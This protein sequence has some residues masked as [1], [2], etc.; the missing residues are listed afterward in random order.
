[1]TT[2]ED[3][4]LTVEV[5]EAKAAL[6]AA[7]AAAVKAEREVISDNH[8]HEDWLSEH[9]GEIPDAKQATAGLGALAEI[10]EGQLELETYELEAEAAFV[11]SA[12]VEAKLEDKVLQMLEM[13]KRVSIRPANAT[14]KA[15]V[16][17][18]SKGEKANK[19]S[20]IVNSKAGEQQQNK[21][22]TEHQ[23]EGAEHQKTVLDEKSEGRQS[24]DSADEEEEQNGS[25]RS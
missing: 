22:V 14:G 20:K 8:K 12:L 2:G 5:L 23:D 24:E 25:R 1:M 17:K 15:T 11:A 13:Q 9:E 7:K 19:A 21:D 3:A 10:D 16:E 18:T 6:L 4:R